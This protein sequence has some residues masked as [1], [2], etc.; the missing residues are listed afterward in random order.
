M[1]KFVPK[2]IRNGLHG[3]LELTMRLVRHVRISKKASPRV[4][5][6]VRVQG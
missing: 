3:A 5:P 6:H 2:F 4:T 1:V